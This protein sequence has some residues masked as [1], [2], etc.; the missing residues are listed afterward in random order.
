MRKLMITLIGA[1]C[2][3]STPVHADTTG[4]LEVFFQPETGESHPTFD[5]YVAH[6]FGWH[7]LGASAFVLVTEGWAEAYAGPTWAPTDWV[8]LGLAVGGQQTA[9]G[10]GL[11]LEASVW[12]GYKSFSFLGVVEFNPQSF[13]GD[14]SGVWFDLTPKYKVLPWLTVGAKYRRPVGLGPLVEL[15]TPSSPSATVWLNWSP[16][17]PEQGDGELV[18]LDRFLVGLKL[19]F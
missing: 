18:H 13:E 2:L 10:I 11:Q 3:L 16:I 19:G 4:S 12:A 17:D 14:D 9:G 5:L 6:N 7:G 15:T 8:E 1:F